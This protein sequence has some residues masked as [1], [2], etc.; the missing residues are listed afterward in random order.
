M[1]E[2]AMAFQHLA[3]AQSFVTARLAT[4]TKAVHPSFLERACSSQSHSILANAQTAASSFAQRSLPMH[5][6]GSGCPWPCESPHPWPL[7]SLHLSDL[8]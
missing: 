5:R 2:W 6:L 4:A 3:L 7:E 8:T 1:G